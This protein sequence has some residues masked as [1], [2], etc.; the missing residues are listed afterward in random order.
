MQRKGASNSPMGFR[1]KKGIE[2]NLLT[3]GRQQAFEFAPIETPYGSLKVICTAR[4]D[5][6][7]PVKGIAYSMF[8]QAPKK[9]A[10]II[11]W[12]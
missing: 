5:D 6:A 7:F 9:L 10:A 11:E 3:N 1:L 2:Q 8:G 4:I 12:P